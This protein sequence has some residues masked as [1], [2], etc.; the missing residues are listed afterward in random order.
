MSET[1]DPQS[2]PQRSAFA[3]ALALGAAAILVICLILVTFLTGQNAVMAL[4]IGVFL[5]GAMSLVALLICVP[6]MKHGANKSTLIIAAGVIILCLLLSG[7][8]S[9]TTIEASVPS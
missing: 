3:W 7:Y 1:I 2:A 6:T 9:V 4:R 5:P 8:G